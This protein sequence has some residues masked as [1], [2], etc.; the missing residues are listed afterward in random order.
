MYDYEQQPQPQGIYPNQF[1]TPIDRFGGESVLLLTNP[2]EVLLKLEMKLRNRVLD[3][4][5]NWVQNQ[6]SF[7]LL[8]EKGIT[9]LM[10]I[11]TAVVNQLTVMS[12]ID[13][14]EVRNLIIYLADV[15][16]YD[17]MMNRYIYE[18]KAAAARDKIY[19]TVINTS[20]L[21]LKRSF[22]QGERVFLTKSQQEIRQT[23]NQDNKQGFLSK[24]FHLGQKAG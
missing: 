4:D 8:N 24:L 14:D 23:S 18:I 2:D 16:A 15:L 6:N 5:G 9:S 13:M 1:S 11:T 20:Y 17:L 7:P 12:N 19:Y 21:C 3:K 22:N 10:H